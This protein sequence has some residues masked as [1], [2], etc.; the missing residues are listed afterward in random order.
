LPFRRDGKWGYLFASGATS[1]AVAIEP[2]FT[3]AFDFCDGFARV[4]VGGADED[5]SDQV[6]GRFGFIDRTG[7]FA[8]EPVYDGAEDFQEG[9]ACVHVDARKGYAPYDSRYYVTGG[10]FGFVD[11]K[12]WRI[13]AEYESASSFS[14][15]LAGARVEGRWGFVDHDGR[16]VIEPR[17]RSGGPFRDALAPVSVSVEKKDLYGYIDPAGAM[18]IEPRWR[19]A[20]EF[21]GGLGLVLDGATYRYFLLGPTGDVVVALP[22][23]VGHALSLSEGLC[24]ASRAEI[25]QLNDG[26]FCP[27]SGGRWGFVD[28]SGA[29]VIEPRFEWVSSFKDGLAAAR[30][31]GK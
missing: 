10:R 3:H 1:G 18:R 24:A 7:A 22:P 21:S 26:S 28:M 30:E 16:L 27:M 13:R 5:D 17:F 31:G 4:N 2:R 14:E 12:G 15:G 29:F 19:L 8:L 6:V 20:Y 9:L 11:A 25:R 23:S